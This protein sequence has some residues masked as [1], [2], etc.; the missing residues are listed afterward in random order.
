[1][2][3]IGDFGAAVLAVSAAVF[4][5]A[6]RHAGRRPVRDPL[7]G[8]VPRRRSLARPARP[9]RGR[10]RLDPGR[11]ANRGRR[12]DRDRFCS[13]GAFI[14]A[15]AAS[16][17]SAGPIL[18]LGTLG[19]FVTAGLVAVRGPLLSSGSIGSRPGSSAPRCSLHRPG[20]DVLRVRSAR[21]PGPVLDHPRGRSGMNDPVGIALMI[22]MIE[23]ATTDGGGFSVVVAEFAREMG[24][25]LAV[26]VGGA[27]P[28]AA[29][30]APHPPH[31]PRALPDQG[32]GRSGDHLRARGRC[33]RVGVLAVLRCGCAPRR[34]GRAAEGRV[35]RTST[36]R[37][38]GWPRSP[39]SS[40]SGYPSGGGRPGRPPTWSD[41]LCSPSS[42]W[43]WPGLSPSLPLLLPARLTRGSGC[44]SVRRLSRPWS[45][46]ASARWPSSP[47]WTGPSTSTGSSSWSCSSPWSSRRARSLHVAASGHPRGGADP[48]SRR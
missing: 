34:R 47:A 46:S 28:A 23:L 4:V 12:A 27:L 1:M 44:S 21:G 38:L 37:S 39:P 31:G 30:D 45:R 5:A 22:G 26:G 18:A 3:E 7:R 15:R 29:R 13:T 32:P 2:D 9:R 48:T 35:S 14:S 43:R 17:C 33:R 10:S 40:R 19:T 42:S 16:S 25:G 36:P 20:G 8:P 24:V 11:R 41:G 6:P